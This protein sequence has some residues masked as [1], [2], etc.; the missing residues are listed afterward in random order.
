[1][2]MDME[3]WERVRRKVLVEGQAKRL[4]MR[5]EGLAWA[6]LKKILENSA[7]PGYR[8]KQSRPKRKLGEHCDGS[9]RCWRRTRRC[10]ASSG[11]RPKGS[12]S[13]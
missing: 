12:W 4:V 8:Q 2:Y 9:N 5:E 10:R 3:L 11:T 13:G 7:P 6:T 1:M